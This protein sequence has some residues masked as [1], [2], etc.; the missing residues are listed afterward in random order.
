MPKEQRIGRKLQRS[1][2]ALASASLNGAERK[3]HLTPFYKQVAP[4][5]FGLLL[6]K[7]QTNW[8]K[9]RWLDFFRIAR[10]ITVA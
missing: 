9:R 6:F 2:M 10:V 8:G 7:R 3:N 4:T 1:D 5:E